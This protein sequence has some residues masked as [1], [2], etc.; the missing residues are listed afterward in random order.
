MIDF[1]QGGKGKSRRLPSTFP[2]AARRMDTLNDLLAASDLVSLHCSLTD[3][4]MHLINADRL[5]HLKPGQ[6]S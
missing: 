4:T 5:Q 2:P 6:F 1:I 3:D